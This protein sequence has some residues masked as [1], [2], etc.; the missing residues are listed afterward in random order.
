MDFFEARMNF[1]EAAR[2]G[3]VDTLRN[4]LEE[5]DL[6]SETDG[7]GRTPLH[8]A[9]ANRR[10]GA[11]N[12]F[13]EKYSNIEHRNHS[14]HTPLHI[15]LLRGDLICLYLLVEAGAY[16]DVEMGGITPLG[17]VLEPDCRLFRRLSASYKPEALRMT[18][19]FLIEAGASVDDFHRYKNAVYRPLHLAWNSRHGHVLP[20]LLEQGARVAGSSHPVDPALH[21]L[22]DAV[23][24]APRWINY[25]KMH[26]RVLAGLVAKLRPIPVDVARIVADFLSLAVAEPE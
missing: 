15:A 21:A 13:L 20:M 9:I 11:V 26:K 6:E 5:H 18:V 8:Y 4:L 7:C 14:G 12:F 1:F 19:K 10:H 16:V 23:A 24:A 22:V 17:F 25:A 2:R 3:D